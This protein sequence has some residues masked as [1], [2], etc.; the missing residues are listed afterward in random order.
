M[1][2]MVLCRCGHSSSLHTE[3]GCRAGRYQP[4]P[5]LLDSHSAIEMAISAARVPPWSKAPGSAKGTDELSK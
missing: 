2:A 4:C 5:C 1:D 3:N